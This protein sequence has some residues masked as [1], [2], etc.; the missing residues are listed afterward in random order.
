MTALIVLTN[1]G[2][3]SNIFDLIAAEKPQ[4]ASII[5]NTVLINRLRYFLVSTTRIF[6]LIAR[7]SV[8]TSDD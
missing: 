7:N 8:E 4:L 2:S 6:F 1:F 3:P 5:T